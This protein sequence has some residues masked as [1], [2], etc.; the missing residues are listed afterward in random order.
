MP[1]LLP[2]SLKVFSARKSMGVHPKMKMK[3]PIVLGEVPCQQHTLQQ[4][5]LRPKPRLPMR[6]LE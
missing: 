1:P 3:G 5:K 6:R 2:H 4:Q